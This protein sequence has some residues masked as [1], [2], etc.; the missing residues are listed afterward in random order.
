MADY[1]WTVLS[2][3]TLGALLA[4]LDGTI[5][6]IS[7]PVIFHGLGVN[8]FDPGSFPLLLWMLL[9]YGV[10]TGTLLVS[11]GRLSDIYGRARMYN[12]GFAI[13]S[14]GSILLFADPLSGYSGALALVLFR[15]VQA[16]GA[17]FLF[18]NS[19]ALLTDAFPSN[20][21]GMAM[22]VNQVAFIGGSMLGLILGGILAGIP[23]IHL[24]PF[25]LPT[26]RTIFLVSVPVGV[27]G[28]I[29]AYARLREISTRRAG[30]RID[31]VGNATFA[32]G[33]I[34]LL[35]S[36]T[37][38]LLPYRSSSTGWG[39]PWVL[40]GLLSGAG[41]LAFFLWVERKVP[42]P[43]FR[44]ELF[45]VRSFTAGISAAFLG[46]I[47]RGG[48]MLL[49]V[50]WL[51]G[52]WLPLHGYSFAETPLWAGIMMT[53]M[54]IGFIVSGPLSGRLS[55]RKGAKTL[56]TLG[57]GIGSITF[58]LLAL[59][60]TDFAYWELGSILFAMGV[61][62]GMFAS[63]N[64]AAIMN[65]VPPENRGASSGMMATLQN[66]GQQASL[67]IFFTFVIVGLSVHLG[68]SVNGALLGAQVGSPDR[69]M[70]VGA[71]SADPTGA[72]FG[73]FLGENPMNGLLASLSQSPG[74]VPLSASTQNTLLAPHFFATAIAAGFSTSLSE[75]FLFAGTLTAVSTLISALRGERYV[76]DEAVG[77]PS[78]R[79]EFSPPIEA[80]GEGK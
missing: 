10:V 29:W 28:T 62:M 53:P 80:A 65:S 5:V 31:Y 67:A 3:T 78:S 40:A 14:L 68:P 17:A 51:Q 44:L 74:W 54:M 30:Q 12:M 48:M 23:D 61:G 50:L 58:F 75:A 35:V 64:A 26:W 36:V 52:I 63:P 39:N 25:V 46:S 38:G 27:G 71:I 79:R 15:L 43:M 16:V 56:A 76:Y 8:P 49:L 47:A 33:L 41:L 55:D 73:A 42:D 32:A 37:Y 24:G 59:L 4:S 7:L 22:G 45:R 18:A 70:L 2:N 19:A 11:F 66:I 69:Q 21:R 9:G 13:F 77:A 6:L 20:E 1:K 72:L 34:L 60:P 57:M